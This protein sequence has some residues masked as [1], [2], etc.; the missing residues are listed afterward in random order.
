MCKPGRR[1][2]GEAAAERTYLQWYLHL[3][4]F[5][6]GTARRT[7]PCELPKCRYADREGERAGRWPQCGHTYS[8]TY[9]FFFFL[10]RIEDQG[11]GSPVSSMCW[12]YELEACAVQ[13]IRVHFWESF[14]AFPLVLLIRSE[15]SER[16]VL[17]V[18]GNPRETH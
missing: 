13:L 10:L 3:F 8:G 15:T 12:A 6:L 16:L 2:S 1:E 18:M 4:F 5:P 17:G 9:P 7:S 11:P 14:L